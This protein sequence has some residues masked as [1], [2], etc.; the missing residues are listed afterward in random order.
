MRSFNI[1]L[2]FSWGKEEDQY[3]MVIES[4]SQNEREPEVFA[5]ENKAKRPVGFVPNG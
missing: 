4:V 3:P 1:T 5:E 2:G